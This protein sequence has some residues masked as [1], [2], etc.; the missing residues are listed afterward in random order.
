MTDKP[1]KED[2][3]SVEE[4]FDGISDKIPQTQLAL[5]IVRNIQLDLHDLKA[6][7]ERLELIK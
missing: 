7:L 1:I 5:E 4:I 2:I 6:E 3:E